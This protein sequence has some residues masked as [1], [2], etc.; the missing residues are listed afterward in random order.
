MNTSCSIKKLKETK[1]SYFD[2]AIVFS[3][4]TNYLPFAIFVANQ[5]MKLEP[6]LSLDICICTTDIEAVPKKFYDSKI[7]FVEIEVNGLDNLPCGRLSASAY[8]R[9]FL[10]DLFAED[11]RYLIYLDADTFIL[12]PFTEDLISYINRLDPN[13]SVAA[14]ADICEL[15]IALLPDSKHKK[16][17]RYVKQY[18]QYNHVYRN[19]GV[20]V[21]NVK[22]FINSNA[23]SKIMSYAFQNINEL[24]CHDQS[25]LNGALKTDIALL[26]F[27][28]NWQVHKLS[29]DLI[30]DYQPYIIHFI[31]ENKPWSLANRFTNSFTDKYVDYFNKNFEN[32]KLEILTP[33]EKRKNNPKYSN[34]FR[35][36]IS[37]NTQRAKSIIKKDSAKLSPKKKNKVK[38]ALDSKYFTNIETS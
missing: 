34:V 32:R 35:E 13:F 25:A 16:T 14:A 12:K 27:T 6:N 29:Y 20:L 11:Y 2:D 22:S 38:K 7:R 31:G 10:P 9:L 28:Y 4:D 37:R 19:S 5:I 30:D 21:L 8:H 36:S 15:Q 1:K 17:Q 18:H 26:P 23:L 24:Q 33:Y 3:V